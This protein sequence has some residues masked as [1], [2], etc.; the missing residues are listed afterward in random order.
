MVYHARTRTAA[1]ERARSLQYEHR[2]YLQSASPRRAHLRVTLSRSCLSWAKVLSRRANHPRKTRKVNAAHCRRPQRRIKGTGTIAL[3]RK[4]NNN[5][6]VSK[7]K[8]GFIRFISFSRVQY[9]CTYKYYI[10]YTRAH[11]KTLSQFVSITSETEVARSCL[12]KTKLIATITR[13]IHVIETYAGG[14]NV[15]RKFYSFCYLIKFIIYV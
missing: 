12:V 10:V 5:T 6:L 1:A 8:S 3:R 4:R 7:R 9:P 11:W 2:R 13:Y 14:T 15:R